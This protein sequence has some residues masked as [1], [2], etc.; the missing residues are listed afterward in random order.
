MRWDRT[1]RLELKYNVC[2]AGPQYIYLP[3]GNFSQCRLGSSEL[4]SW[5][6]HISFLFMSEVMVI[7]DRHL[8]R[9]SLFG[10]DSPP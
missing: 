9:S 10:L 3:V 4:S 5:L 8:F 6:V 1:V 2:I 7:I